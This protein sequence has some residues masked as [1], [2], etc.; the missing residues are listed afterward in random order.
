MEIKLNW[1]PKTESFLFNNKLFSVL[2]EEKK[3]FIKAKK[4]RKYSI[5]K[6]RHSYNDSWGNILHPLAAAAVGN[7]I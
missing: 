5:Q 2:W 1:I 4:R 3:L 7:H 6:T